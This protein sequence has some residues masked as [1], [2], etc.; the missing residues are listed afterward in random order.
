MVCPVCTIAVGLGVGILRQF[1]V[2]D[3]ITGMWFG[4]LIVSCIGWMINFLNKKNIHFLFRKILVMII[5]YAM[6]IIPLFP[7]NVMSRLL[8]YGIIIGTF[9][10]IAAMLSDKYLR[11]LNESKALI[12]YQK[13]FIPLVYLIIGS[14]I[15]HLIIKII[16]LS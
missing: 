12:Y 15:A 16:E 6:F 13:I 2:S 9:I 4:A 3:I 11:S 8:A 1:G 7:L 5:F 14:I 10:F